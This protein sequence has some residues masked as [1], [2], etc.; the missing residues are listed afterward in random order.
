MEGKRQRKEQKNDTEGMGE[1]GKRKDNKQG[2]EYSG[3]L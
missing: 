3:K 1:Y 2:D